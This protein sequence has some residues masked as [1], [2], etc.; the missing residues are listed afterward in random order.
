M[1]VR[2]SE[3]GRERDRERE[4]LEEVGWHFLDNDDSRYLPF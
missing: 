4:D 1:R 3:G 2:V